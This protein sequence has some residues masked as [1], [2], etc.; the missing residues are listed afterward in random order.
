M[1]NQSNFAK[2]SMRA[3]S[4]SLKRQRSR[5]EIEP[6]HAALEP[7]EAYAKKIAA[8]MCEPYVVITIPD[9]STAHGMG[10][11]FA[12]IPESELQTY[13]DGGATLAWSPKGG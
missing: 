5:L 3:L 11:R 4:M 13:I 8:L 10:Y 12:S 1:N 7:V 6:I 9:G 2:D